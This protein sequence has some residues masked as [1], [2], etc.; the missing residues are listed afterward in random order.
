MTEL[1]VAV[2][3]AGAGIL[4]L[5]LFDKANIDRNQKKLERKVSDNDKA[6]ARLEG[7][8]AQEDR[9]TQNKVDEIEKEQNDSPTGS[10]L[11]DWFNRRK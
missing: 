8:Q 2:L 3:G 5:R 10:N 11:A 7:E 6:Q 4:I 9:E 1:I